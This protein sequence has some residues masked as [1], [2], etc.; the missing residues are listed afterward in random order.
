M[1]AKIEILGCTCRVGMELDRPFICHLRLRLSHML[2]QLSSREMI[3]LTF[4]LRAKNFMAHCIRWMRHL[5][6]LALMG[7]LTTFL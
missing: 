6:E 7:T 5:S 1:A 3:R 4:F 2:I